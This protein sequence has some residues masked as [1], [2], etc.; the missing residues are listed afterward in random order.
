[1]GWER[2]DMSGR[3]DEHGQVWGLEAVRKLGATTDIETAAAILGI[4]RTLAFQLARTDRFPVPVLRIGDRRMRISVAELLRYLG[5][6]P[7]KR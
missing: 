2:F 4:G 5:D 3:D 7:E 6:P 1:V